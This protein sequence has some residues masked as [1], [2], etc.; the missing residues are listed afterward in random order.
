MFFQIGLR[1]LQAP[2]CV[3][4]VAELLDPDSGG[5]L[6]GARDI[7]DAVEDG[8]DV[9]SAFSRVETLLPRGVDEPFIGRRICAGA[10][11]T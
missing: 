2:E 5:K 4:G 9:D 10:S 7:R 6:Y 8:R 1:R 3:F 11:L